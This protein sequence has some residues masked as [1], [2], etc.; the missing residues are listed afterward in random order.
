MSLKRIAVIFGIVFVIVGVLGWVPA[1]NPG[2]KL[3]GIFDVN[4]RQNPTIAGHASYFTPMLPFDTGSA[5]VP[6]IASTY[7]LA[8]VLTASATH[9]DARAALTKVPGEPG[10]TPRYCSNSVLRTE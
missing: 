6:V 9:W 3:L 4:P 2:G 5:R 8:A 7:P 1:A 10:A